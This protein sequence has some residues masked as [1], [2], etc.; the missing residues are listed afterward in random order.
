MYHGTTG[1]NET[2]SVPS[3]TP[4]G[5]NEM[6]CSRG[7]ATT[8][9]VHDKRLR[10][11]PPVL[12]KKH[13]TTCLH[14]WSGM[15]CQDMDIVLDAIDYLETTS[16]EPLHQDMFLRRVSPCVVSLFIECKLLPKCF[17]SNIYIY[18]YILPMCHK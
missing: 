3:T 8:P 12:E 13:H 11:S 6:E 17:R 18:I 7:P 14:T 10:S 4:M 2:E 1:G 16:K 9:G 5:R 15:P